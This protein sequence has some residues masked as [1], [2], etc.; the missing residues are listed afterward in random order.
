LASAIT[1]HKSQ[2]KQFDKVVID[3][4]SGAF[5]HGQLYVAISRCKTLAGLVLKRQV[6][7][8]DVI[9]DKRVVEFCA[10]GN[11]PSFRLVPIASPL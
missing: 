10:L 8:R 9:V 1:I 2:G 7:L 4:G 3:L 11:Q 6:R 5:A